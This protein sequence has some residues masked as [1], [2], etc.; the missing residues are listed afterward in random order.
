MGKHPGSIDRHGASWRVRLCVAGQRHTFH[1]DGSL[2]QEAVEQQARERHAELHRR[3]GKGLPGPMR[4]SE[5]LRRYRRAELPQ[6]SPNSQRTYG[7]SLHAFETYFVQEG[8]DPSAHEIR[9]GHIVAFMTWRRDHAPDGS[10]VRR[11]LSARTVNKDRVVLHVVFAFGETLE[12]VDSNPVRKTK[13]R[14]GDPREPL[15]LDADQYEKLLGACED[16][17]MVA[18]YVLTLGETGVRCDSE[19]L[20]LRWEDVD[21]ERGFLTVESVR[22]GR[23]T[24]S[25]KSRKVPMTSRL[26]KAM[27]EHMAAYRMKTYRGKRTAWVFH[28]ELA[29]RHAEPGDRI[30]GLRRAF[31][32]AVKRAS[33]PA[34]L[35]QHDLRHRRITTWL[36]DGHPIA[37]VAKAMGHSS[38]KVTEGYLHLVDRD[39]L[40]LVEE[41]TEEE[42][43]ALVAR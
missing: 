11:T 8:S 17:P 43:R 34:D 5:L 16:R 19:A 25:G 41:P 35:R 20:W 12:I 38:L 9:P 37:I 6:L 42:L 39:L 27:A 31:A 15:I 2:D 14:K 10:K 1:L 32:G 7:A 33:L 24:K 40:P 23:R 36:Q 3:N 4:F 29:R 18:L 28:H 30:T 13:P 26:R 22:K 21:L